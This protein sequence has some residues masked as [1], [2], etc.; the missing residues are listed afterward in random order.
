VYFLYSML[1]AAGML[2]LAP[3]WA[4]KGARTGKYWQNF[5]ERM[6]SLPPAVIETARAA[7][8]GNAIWIHAVSV[9][10]VLAVRPLAQ[11]LKQRFPDRGLF[12]ST[13]TD[14][15]QKLARDRLDFADG[16]FY[17]PLDWNHAVRRAFRAIQP[18][19]IVV[20]ET[21]IWPNFLR[22]ASRRNIPVVFV[23]ARISERSV[24]RFRVWRHVAGGFFERVLND[25]SMYL[26]QSHADA[27]RL[28]ELGA[29]EERVEVSGNLKYD[30]EPPVMGVFGEWLAAQVQAQ[31]RWPLVVAGS[32]VAEEEEAV[33]AA[34]DIVQRQWRRSLLILAP[35]KPDRFDAAAQIT[36]QV[37]WKVVRRS[38]IDMSQPLS[39]DVDVLILDSIG[40]LAGIYSFADAVFVGGSLVPSGG[41]NILEPAWFARPPVFGPSMENFRDMAQQF[42]TE[43]AGVQVR[44]A[45][46][47]GKTWTQLIRDTPMRERMGARAQELARL[48]RGAT[49]R[50]LLRIEEIL[51]ASASASA[52]QRGAA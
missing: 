26:A 46:Q 45:D 13:T 10:E 12:I 17:F 33:L 29:P 50:S 18:A 47:L 19:L 5:R 40:E 43:G 3:Y 28:R 22:E 35:R 52:T 42:R 37:G 25:A 8:P 20:V 38:A 31:E 36:A 2:L 30:A 21:E 11:K 32:V 16:V 39:D 6:G 9:G 7:A 51:A 4:I 49:E 27:D 15:G 34:Y 44:T 41:H 1:T 48:N 24:R 23:N 14:T